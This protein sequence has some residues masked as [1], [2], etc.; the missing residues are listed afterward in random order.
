MAPTGKPSW[1]AGND[2]QPSS[3]LHFTRSFA[4]STPNVPCPTGKPQT[5]TEFMSSKSVKWT[6]LSTHPVNQS[7]ASISF[8]LHNSSLTMHSLDTSIHTAYVVTLGTHPS[9]LQFSFSTLQKLYMLKLFRSSRY[10]HRGSHEGSYTQR[11]HI[12]LPAHTPHPPT[13]PP[14]DSPL[15]STTT[16]LSQHTQSF[17]PTTTSL[18]HRVSIQQRWLSLFLRQRQLSHSI[19]T[20]QTKQSFAMRFPAAIYMY[21]PPSLY[22]KRR[23]DY[24]P[25]N[26]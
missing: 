13:M 3:H 16:T 21:L 9:E 4:P 12:E 7:H 26:T 23:C 10:I 20:I 19:K 11:T 5:V 15:H 18:S 22:A 6:A 8:Q 24:M 2:H 25:W 14:K 1:K 17:H